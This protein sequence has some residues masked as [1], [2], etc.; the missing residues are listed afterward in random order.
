MVVEAAVGTGEDARV[1]GAENQF[2]LGDLAVMV[3]ALDEVMVNLVLKDLKFVEVED[4]L[5]LEI[6]ELANSDIIGGRL[7]G[8][9]IAGV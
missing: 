6:V 7:T 1:T 9:N 4:V 5:G 3:V 2:V 8:W